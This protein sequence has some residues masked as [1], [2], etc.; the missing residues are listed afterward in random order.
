M[1]GL[2]ATA[3]ANAGTVATR[4]AAPAANMYR[5]A[6]L[7]SD[8]AG[9][10]RVTDRALVNPWGMSA[11]PGTPVWVSDNN[12]NTTT[13]YMGDKN[14]TPVSQVGLVKIAGGN[15]TGQVFNGTSDFVVKSGGT[16]GP[17][18]FL[19]ASE[20]G[21]IT[22]WNGNGGV[23]VRAV[24]VPNAVYK[25]LA[26]ATTGLGNFLFA[27]NFH[28]G[29]VDMFDGRFKMIPHPGL[30]EDPKL[31]KG[32][33]P[34]NVAVFGDS[35]YVSYALQNAAM[36]DDVHGPG[37]GFIDVYS[38]DGGM[39]RRLISHGPL[40][41]P[42]GMVMAPSGFGAFSGDLLIGNFGNGWINAFD[43]TTGN[44]V[45]TLMNTDGNPVAIEGLWGLIFGDSAIA[46]S[47]TLLFSAGIAGEQ[48]GLL[49]SLR[50]A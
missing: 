6:N 41:S 19:F 39:R 10:A 30:F 46:S 31:P 28:S 26:M 40:N 25:G 8:I 14:G 3:T 4:S 42:W 35:L 49:G 11:G 29:Q 12:S 48:H 13:F 1:G 2:A 20:N 17:A 43:P 5:Q 33:A 21:D 9:V 23:A 7:V 44:Q 27:A 34:F 37:H 18:F 50:P 47:R 15:P 16:P 22:G 36:H 24:S 38:F 45:G 32:Y